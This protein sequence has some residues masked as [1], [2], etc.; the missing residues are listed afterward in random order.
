MFN[1]VNCS[2][3]FQFC[4]SIIV[5]EN[6]KKL[7]GTNP[8][9]ISFCCIHPNFE[10]SRQPNNGNMMNDVFDEKLLPQ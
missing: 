7:F 2:I 8:I 5:E 3:C 6:C 4:V 9:I 10:A 1:N